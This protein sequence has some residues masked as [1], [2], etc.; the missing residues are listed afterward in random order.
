MKKGGY[1]TS[2]K[3]GTWGERVAVLF[4]QKYAYKILEQNFYTRFGEIDVVAL[5]PNND[6]TFVEVKTRRKNIQVSAEWSVTAGKLERLRRAIDLYVLYK[7][8]GIRYNGIAIECVAVY[9]GGDS[10]SIKK[11]FL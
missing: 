9:V 10:V 8:E 7:G 6:L 5:S 2:Q 1:T 3:L 11:Y 4:L